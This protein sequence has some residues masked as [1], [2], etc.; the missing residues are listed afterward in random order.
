MSKKTPEQDYYRILQVDPRACDEVI[1]A[2]YLALM[3][4]NHPDTKAT[5]GGT[6]RLINE[7]YETLSDAAKRAAYD[8]TRSQVDGK[9]I[10]DYRVLERIAEGG[11]GKTYKGEHVLTGMPVCIKHCSKVS[12][13]DEIIM[14]EEAQA[15][16]KLRHYGIP[17][18]HNLIRLEDGSLA[19]VM[20]YI[21]GPTLA[22]LVEQNGR[23][24]PED[25]AWITER[26]L[27]ILKYTH[28]YEV[29]HGDV[30]P[31]NVIVDVDRHMVTLVDFGLAAVKPTA[32]TA[33]KGYTDIFAPPEQVKGKPLLP[34]TDFYSLGMTMIFALSGDIAVTAAK[35]VPDGTPD[36][37]CKF[38]KRLIV[39]DVDGRP[40]WPDGK[41]G[42]EDLQET[43]GKV[44]EKAFKRRSSNM[45]PI[46]S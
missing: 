27:N 37:L 8:A 46:N 23:L 42:G 3:K 14:V 9:L 28:F 24:E 15:M 38:I 40:Q 13:E 7:A 31:Q 11:C 12:P 32:T 22:Q 34:Q 19:L 41:G 21:E 20:S 30:K 5:K 35:Q 17:A 36:E 6:A 2:S 29:A 1:K 44:R 33:A 39:R 10:G 4:V 26:L 16:W 25:V 45:K 18:I 43:L